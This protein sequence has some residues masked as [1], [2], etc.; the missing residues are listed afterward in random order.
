MIGVFDSGFGGL[1][2]YRQI[3]KVL[4]DYDLIYLGDSKRVPYGSRSDETV[5]EWT[6]EAVDFLF[7]KGCQLIIIA[8]HTASNL[9]LRRI[10]QEYLPKS[11]YSDR[12]V[13][14]VTIPI[15]EGVCRIARKKVGVVA[16][17][18]TC[19]SRGFETEIKKLRPDLEVFHNPA[20]LLVPIVE[21]GLSRSPECKRTIKR[22]LRPLQDKQIDTLLLGCTHYPLLHELFEKRA[23]KAITV[24]YTPTLVTDSLQDYLKRHPEIEKKLEKKAIRKIMTTDD[25]RDFETMG[26][27]FLGR[28][29]EA[30]KVQL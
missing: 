9:A 22:A 19:R 4:G 5:H 21:E 10:Q 20:P 26:R 8:C 11:P 29:F 3:E 14:G 23:G 27:G 1:C 15:V 18:S 13:L 25:P 17:R 24:P 28:S 16:T 12:R 2:I 7:E 6:E 30:L